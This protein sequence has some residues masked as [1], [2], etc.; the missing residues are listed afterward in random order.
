MAASLSYSAQEV[1]R[2]DRDRFGTALFAPLQYREALFSLYAFNAEVARVRELVSEPLL[3]RMRLQWWRDAIAGFY[4]GRGMAHPVA[5]PLAEA[6]A[7][8]Q[9]SREPFDRLLDTRETD[10]EDSGPAD[11][12]GL[13]AYA[14]GTS[15]TLNRLALE[16]LGVREEAAAKAA[17]H[18]GIAWALTGLL[19]AVPFHASMGRLYL[20]PALLAEYGVAAQDLMAGR[21]PPGLPKVAEAVATRARRH[22]ADAR[23][24]RRRVPRAA[25]PALLAAALAEGYLDALSHSGND[26]MDTVWSMTHPRPLRL[27]WQFFRG[28]Y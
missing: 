3:G 20:P 16:I 17:H 28:M 8:R 22:L 23:A 21:R 19:R 13:E 18:V 5:A 4:E 12:D 27:G 1:R 15:A 24:L 14:E 7:S 26:L 10:M 11:L 6:I 25:L 2:Y 9:L